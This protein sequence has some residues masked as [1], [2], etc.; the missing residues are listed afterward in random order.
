M[1]T[2]WLGTADMTHVDPSVPQHLAELYQ[3]LNASRATLLAL[4]EAEGSGI[5]RRT[6]DQLDRMIAEIF[7]P[8]ESV[9]YGEDDASSSDNAATVTPTGYAWRVTG[10]N[11][12]IRTLRCDETGQE[13][14]VSIERAINDFALVPTHLPEVYFPDL[15]LNPPQLEGKYAQRGHDHPFLTNYQWLQAVRNTQ[16]QLG[17]WQWVLAELSALHRSSLS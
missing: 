1:H 17:Y 5:H 15:D 11:G 9:V 13:I 8:L 12:D 6:L 16:T 4:I 10:R 14:S 3:E 2:P 7:F